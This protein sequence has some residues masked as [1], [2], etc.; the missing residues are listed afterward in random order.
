MH[1]TG[2]KQALIQFIYNKA[3]EIVV[4]CI[5]DMAVPCSFLWICKY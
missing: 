4:G 1:F 2:Y 5:S 3:M